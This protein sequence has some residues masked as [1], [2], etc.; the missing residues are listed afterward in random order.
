M[1]KSKSRTVLKKIGK[2]LKIIFIKPIKWIYRKL[3]KKLTL[4]KVLNGI[5]K[6][7]LFLVSLGQVNLMKDPK[8]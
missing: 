6:L 7:F 2:V 8:D 3:K 4:K 5:W 1:E